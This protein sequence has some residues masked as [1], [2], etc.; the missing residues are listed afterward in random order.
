MNILWYPFLALLSMSGIISLSAAS[1]G[2]GCC[3]VSNP[4]SCSTS[5]G[6]CN[7]GCREQ[8]DY[9]C[10]SCVSTVLG[11]SPLNNTAYFGLLPYLYEPDTDCCNGGFSIGYQLQKSFGSCE[12]ARAIAG[13]RTLVFQG[14]RVSKRSSSALMAD[15]FGLSQDFS[16]SITLSPEITSNNLNFQLYFGWDA[17]APGFYTTFE[18]AYAAQTRQLFESACAQNCTATQIGSNTNFPPAYMGQDTVVPIPTILDA[19]SGENLFGDMQS[20]WNYGKWSVDSLTDHKVAGIAVNVG[21]NFLFEEN[22]HLGLYVRYVAPTGTCR[23]GS[24]KYA[25][26]L[27]AP[28]IGNGH[29]HEFGAGLQGHATL[30]TFN[31][32]DTI[33]CFID[34]YAT[35]L[36]AHDQIRSFDLK[37][38]GCM[39]RYM[40][41]KQLQPSAINPQLDPFVAVAQ[42]VYDYVGANGLIPAI[43][44][45]TRNVTSSFGVQGDAS[46][47]CIYKH[48]GLSVAIGYNVFG[49]SREKLCV[50]H[51]TPCNGIDETKSY[52]IKGCQGV[53]VYDYALDGAGLVSGVGTVAPLNSTASTATITTCGT[54]DAGQKMLLSAPNDPGI[55][56]AWDNVY[57]TNGMP[58]N[59][60]TGLPSSAD[61]AIAFLSAPARALTMNDLAIDAGT[62]PSYLTNKGFLQI[63]YVMESVCWEPFI[64]FGVEVETGGCATSIDQWGFWLR[65][66]LSF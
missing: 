12:L 5:A 57:S 31:C 56:I 18:L 60:V 34:G 6:G 32:G 2:A 35:H 42:R 37:Q 43:N 19:L 45:T 9:G 26:Y 4:I 54:A 25:S 47:R 41:L 50:K 27:F 49:R 30:W 11:R 21:Y 51:S 55:G 61:V 59:D 64:G 66:G 16:G 36:F 24:E 8:S 44:Y 52:G 39:S 23:D 22:H 17:I 28:L 1:A 20:K 58:A 7:K 13:S 48:N 38:R 65:T 53:Y 33:S 29:Y 10:F 62:I 40:L 14:S 46:L 3:D 15:Y 63:D